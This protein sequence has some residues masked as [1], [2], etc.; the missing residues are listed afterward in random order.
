[1][2]GAAANQQRNRT[3]QQTGVMATLKYQGVTVS[4]PI[5][6]I[7]DSLYSFCM[8]AVRNNWQGVGNIPPQ[9]EMGTGTGTGTGGGGTQTIRRQRKPMT[10]AHKEKLRIAAA[11][12]AAQQK[13]QQK[14][15]TA[16]STT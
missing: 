3:Q 5:D 13:K 10:E 15:M 11:R 9:R 6:Q 14:T 1:M 7:W 4:G 12:R 8:T 16:G 2:S